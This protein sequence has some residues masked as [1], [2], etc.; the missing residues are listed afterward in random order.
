MIISLWILI[1]INS[2]KRIKLK[3]IVLKESKVKY[4]EELRIMYYLEYPK[5]CQ[6]KDWVIGISIKIKW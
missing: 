5:K 6:Y 4:L 3:K 2:I 1:K